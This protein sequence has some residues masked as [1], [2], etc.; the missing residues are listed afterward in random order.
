MQIRLLVLFPLI[1]FL[2]ITGPVRASGPDLDRVTFP[3]GQ[4]AI[5]IA[6]LRA[7][8]RFLVPVQINGHDAG[9]FALDTG[10]SHI[11]IARCDQ[12]CSF[13][14]SGLNAAPQITRKNHRPFQNPVMSIPS[15]CRS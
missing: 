9:L 1:P 6:L 11:F 4:V 5:Q 2:L 14:Q 12:A 7:G 15:S 10:A 8:S 3:Q 13:K